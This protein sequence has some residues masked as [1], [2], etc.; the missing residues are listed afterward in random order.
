[1]TNW[2]V[3]VLDGVK[4]VTSKETIV[5]I[6]PEPSEMKICAVEVPPGVM[7]SAGA[8]FVMTQSS[9]AGMAAD[10]RRVKGAAETRA[11][12]RARNV[13]TENMPFIMSSFD[14]CN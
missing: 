4:P 10:P 9:L 2:H 14:V 8:G 13:A 6:S 3:L 12:V 1:M 11:E 7:I 5:S